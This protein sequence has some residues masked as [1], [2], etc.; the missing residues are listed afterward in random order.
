MLGS[1]AGIVAAGQQAMTSGTQEDLGRYMKAHGGPA[2]EQMKRKGYLSPVVPTYVMQDRTTT[3]QES[4]KRNRGQ[5]SKKQLSLNV[6][7]RQGVGALGVREGERLHTIEEVGIEEEVVAGNG[8]S[9]TTMPEATQAG[10]LDL[11]AQ[12]R[13]QHTPIA[14]NTVPTN[15]EA[16]ANADA[17]PGPT[18]LP[19][20]GIEAINNYVEWV[21]D[22]QARTAGR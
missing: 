12:P 18:S 21:R 11:A 9:V 1:V 5:K 6:A 22:Y 4:I 15:R 10:A 8:R 3:N 16:R 14:G 17:I 2:R 7:T 19:V 13:A 20:A